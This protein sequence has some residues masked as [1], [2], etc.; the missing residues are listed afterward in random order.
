[1]GLGNINNRMFYKCS[2]VTRFASCR[3][4]LSESI[5]LVMNFRGEKGGRGEKRILLFLILPQLCDVV[6]TNRLDRLA[7]G[8]LISVQPLRLHSVAL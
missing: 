4:W 6:T 2:V 5:F 3:D 8:K 1:M 7:L